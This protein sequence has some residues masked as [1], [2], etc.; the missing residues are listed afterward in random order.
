MAEKI[1]V[2]GAGASGRGHVGLLAWQA[3]FEMVFVDKK[4][5]LVNALRRQGRYTVKLYG[6]QPQE[7]VASGCRVYHAQER[8]GH[9]RGD[10]RRLPGAHGGVRPEPARRGP[11]DRAGHFRLCSVSGRTAPLNCIACENMMDSSTT[12]GNHVRSLAASLPTAPGAKGTSGFR[13]A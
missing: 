12:L 8:R 5:A 13:T 7:I 2:F 6:R 11:D 10:S 1:V 9:C 3:G 4:P